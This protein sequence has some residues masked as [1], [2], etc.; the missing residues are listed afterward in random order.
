MT[1]V[2]KA[3]YAFLG[4][5]T[6]SHALN[7]IYTGILSPFLPIIQDELALSLTE[8]G[9]VSSAAIIA[10]TI[11][12][13]IVGYLGDQ[14]W[15]DIFIPASVFLGAFIILF[16]SFATSFVFLTVS[17]FLLGVGV[18]GYHPSVFPAIAESFPLSDRAKATGIQAMGG[19]I[20]MALI[21]FIGISLLV[22][23]D[24]WRASFV[25]VASFSFAMFIPILAIMKY[26]SKRP[27]QSILERKSDDGADGWTRNFAL[28]IAL[29][30]F[31]GM[32]FRSVTLL[33]P[34]YLV[35]SSYAFDPIL[36]GIFTTIMLA[37]GLVGEIVAAPLSDRLG[38]RLPF[39]I[40]STAVTT[41]LILLLN[42]SLAKNALLVV[43][44]AIGFFFFLGVPPAT[45]YETQ[46]APRQSQGVAFGLLFS[47]GSIPGSISPIIFGFLGDSY[48]LSMSIVY[49]A[50]A[51]G[52][53]T[54]VSMLLKEK[55]KNVPEGV[56]SEDPI[57]VP[58]G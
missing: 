8:A 14:G 58:L 6:I 38:R 43:L 25:L 51:A 36:A 49:L 7:H 27:K 4:A 40:I 19:L 42:A 21:P 1:K 37:A 31:R 15:R 32:F 13:L 54:I 5:C 16:S 33:M 20:G 2:T 17:M 46:A 22:L 26:A 23:L 56:K 41:P 29:T 28:L 48:G 55:T 18:S 30:S 57:I 3:S 9:I 53:A 45:A 50:I 11:S 44:I 35:Q 47:I 39:L 34:L 12:H 10:M 52:L 24:G